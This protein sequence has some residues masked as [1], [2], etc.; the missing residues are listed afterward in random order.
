MAVDRTGRRSGV[1]V[2]LICQ[3]DHAMVPKSLVKHQ[4]R[5]YCEGIFLDVIIIEISRLWVKQM[6]LRNVGGPQPI[7]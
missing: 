5:C 2:N 6:A 3:L 7:N 1:M 4:S